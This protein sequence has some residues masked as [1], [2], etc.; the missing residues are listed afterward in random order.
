M[1]LRV[2]VKPGQREDHLWRDAD[3]LLVA[4]IKAAPKDGEANAYLVKFLAESFGVAKSLVA[5]KNG[6]AS[7]FKTVVINVPEADLW[8]ALEC[9]PTF[10]HPLS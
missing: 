8:T 1:L 2:R 4:H 6:A 9:L 3:G 5:V 7:R 10:P